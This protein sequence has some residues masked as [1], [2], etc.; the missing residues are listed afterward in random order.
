MP[1]AGSVMGSAVD[2]GALAPRVPLPNVR[3]VTKPAV[4]FFTMP[5]LPRNRVPPL[6]VTVAEPAVTVASKPRV[7]FSAVVTPPVNVARATLFALAPLVRASTM[8]F[9][10]S[11]EVNVPPS[12][13]MAP[14][15]PAVTWLATVTVPVAVSDP[16]E[17]VIAP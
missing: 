7:S 10:A 8:P 16:P 6:R 17:T 5:P 4:P 13:R 2:H 3:F 11:V 1:A 9:T 12:T 15:R 14:P